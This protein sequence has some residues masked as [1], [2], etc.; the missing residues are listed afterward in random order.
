MG[1]KTAH[2]FQVGIKAAIVKSGKLLLLVDETDESPLYDLPGGRM[3]RSES[4][5]E[6]V[7]RE[8]QEEL[9]GSSN[10]KVEKYLF[11][12]NPDIDLKFNSSLLL[13]Y[14]KVNCDLPATIKLSHEHTDYLWVEKSDLPKLKSSKNFRLP[15]GVERVITELF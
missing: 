10:F 8:T 11:T 15:H 14:Y 12:W 3:E 1:N 7:I 6:A 5:E 9:P 13:M 2:L 4:V